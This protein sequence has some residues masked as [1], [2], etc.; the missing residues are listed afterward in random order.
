MFYKFLRV[1]VQSAMLSDIV[2]NASCV[3]L[4]IV[5]PGQNVA[6]LIRK[7]EMRH[8]FRTS[9]PENCIVLVVSCCSVPMFFSNASGYMSTSAKITLFWS[10]SSHSWFYIVAWNSSLARTSGIVASC[11]LDFASDS[12]SSQLQDGVQPGSGA[13]WV[14]AKTIDWSNHHLLIFKVA[15]PDFIFG[16]MFYVYQYIIVVQEP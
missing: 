7:D 4:I 9:D 11:L 6:L 5:C 10:R 3:P 1:R 12:N 8:N 13:L 2:S 14:P 15:L 16:R